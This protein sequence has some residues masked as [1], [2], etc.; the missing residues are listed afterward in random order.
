[1]SIFAFLTAYIF[2]EII[3]AVTML[4]LFCTFYE[5]FKFHLK[6]IEISKKE[7]K[8]VFRFPFVKLSNN[9]VSPLFVTVWYI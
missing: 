4:F 8:M 9:L 2:E 3:L 7:K 1:M 6:G 5:D